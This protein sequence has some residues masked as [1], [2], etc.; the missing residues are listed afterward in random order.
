MNNLIERVVP[1]EFSQCVGCRVRKNA[2]NL[3]QESL[4]EL[5]ENTQVESTTECIPDGAWHSHMS[6]VL[7]AFFPIPRKDGSITYWFNKESKKRSNS[8]RVQ[9]PGLSLDE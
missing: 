4:G 9:C 2:I 6:V 1:I 8:S 5:P 3:V 7:R